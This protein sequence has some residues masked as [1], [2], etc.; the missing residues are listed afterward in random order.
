MIQSMDRA[1]VVSGWKGAYDKH[2]KQNPNDE[3]G[4]IRFADKV[5]RRTQ[6]AF[7]IKDLPSFFRGG[8]LERMFTM[9]M[10]Q[11]NQNFNFLVN[12]IIGKG[13]AGTISKPEMLRRFL[14]WMSPI[15]VLGAMS[16]GRLP[17]SAEEWA[18]DIIS[19]PL[20]GVFLVGSI[21]DSMVKG[22]DWSLP[23]FQPI[24]E[25]IWTAKSKKLPTKVKHGVK[26]LLYLKGIPA[27]YPF[28]LGQGAVDLLTGRTNDL[29]RLL[30][31]EH[32]L[33]EPKGPQIKSF[34]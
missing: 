3:V 5:I 25:A 29:R 26:T 9:F 4:A 34:P 24:K 16:R 11:R 17:V 1:T 10:N 22:F 12:D 28:R 33:R 8:E 32:A 23:V 2:L 6:P 20:G 31:S 13:K 14:W 15:L 19:Y 27:N 7:D 21:I 18:E 30:F